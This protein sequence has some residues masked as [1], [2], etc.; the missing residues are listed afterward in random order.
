MPTISEE[1]VA[2][3]LA[4]PSHAHA[5]GCMIEVIALCNGAAL[6]L[7]PPA[8]I[9]CCSDELMSLLTVATLRTHPMAWTSAG[10]NQ[11]QCSCPIRAR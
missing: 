3:S 6:F 10:Q 5:S 4:R 9:A 2:P 11:I 1:P 7:Y 8:L